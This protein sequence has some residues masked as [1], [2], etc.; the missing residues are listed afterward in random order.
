MGFVGLQV[1]DNNPQ[2]MEVPVGQA[3]SKHDGGCMAR[4]RHFHAEVLFS[5]S[6][7]SPVSFIWSGISTVYGI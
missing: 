2:S 1:S 6:S 5:A 3:E 4:R 7:L